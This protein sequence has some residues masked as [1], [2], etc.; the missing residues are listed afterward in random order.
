[1]Q[2]LATDVGGL[3]KVLTNVSTRGAMGEIQ[4]ERILDQILAPS[5]YAKN[6]K[7]HPAC[8]GQ[9]EFAIKMPQCRREYG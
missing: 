6:V 7:T 5:Q 9:V 4:A 8:K 3:K 2:T 1:M